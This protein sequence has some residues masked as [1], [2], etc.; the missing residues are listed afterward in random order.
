MAGRSSARRPLRVM[1]VEDEAVV[2]ID[3]ECRLQALGYDVV[4]IADT[5]TDAVALFA[6]TLPDLVLLDIRLRDREDGIEVARALRARADRPIVIDG[7]ARMG[8]RPVA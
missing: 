8:E 1:I 7:S 3:L 2:A 5:L 4:G 6:K